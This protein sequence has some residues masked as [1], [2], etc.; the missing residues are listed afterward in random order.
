V[1][2]RSRFLD[3]GQR[4]PIG[5]F[6]QI[7]DDANGRYPLQISHIGFGRQ[8]L[9]GQPGR[10]RHRVEAIAGKHR[11]KWRRRLAFRNVVVDVQHRHAIGLE[12]AVRVHTQ[13]GDDERI[14]LLGQ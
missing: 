14:G 4:L 2:G 8:Q 6:A 11:G 7:G 10:A 9:V 12:R 1:R 5:L 3:L 13:V